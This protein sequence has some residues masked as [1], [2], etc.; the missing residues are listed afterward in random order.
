MANKTPKQRT[1]QSSLSKA[2]DAFDA[3][4]KRAGKPKSSRKLPIQERPL[5]NAFI[6]ALQDVSQKDFY[7]KVDLDSEDRVFKSGFD[8]QLVYK[9]RVWFFEAKR[10]PMKPHRNPLELL[11]QFQFITGF[12]IVLSSSPYFILEFVVNMKGL[13]ECRLYRLTLDLFACS[14]KDID[15]NDLD[16][17]LLMKAPTV[18]G[19]A[20]QFNKVLR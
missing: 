15:W 18:Q 8:F 14:G 13:S 11:S 2:L 20:H 10:S 19:L 17:K 5:V 4:S 12:E 16:N 7:H 9:G 1:F 6:E 3:T